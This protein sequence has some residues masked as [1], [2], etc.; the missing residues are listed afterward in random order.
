MIQTPLEIFL[1]P[2][3]YVAKQL[4]RIGK[5]YMQ[6]KASRLISQH[7][8]FYCVFFSLKLIYNNTIT[9]QAGRVINSI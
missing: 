5:D 2:L 1:F 6:L 7:T 9:F 4:C 8:D 3:L